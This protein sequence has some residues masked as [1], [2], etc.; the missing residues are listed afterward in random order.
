M[1][2]A[3]V[4]AWARADLWNRGWTAVDD[5][6]AESCADVVLAIEKARGAHTFAG[7]V[8]GVYLNVRR[9]AI[10]AARAPVT[11]LEG[12]DPPALPEEPID[13]TEWRVL[14]GCLE[15]LPDREREA[16]RLRYFEGA[17]AERIATTLAVTP[18]NARRIVFNG[19]AKVRRCAKEALRARSGYR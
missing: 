13:V 16:V 3:G 5:A 17:A 4:R 8:R 9:R 18:G 2:D 14:D 1:L 15:A 7:F 12:V 19:L 10:A 11:T 6:V